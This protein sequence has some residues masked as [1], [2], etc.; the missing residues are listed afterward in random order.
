METQDKLN[1]KVMLLKNSKWDTKVFNTNKSH[2]TTHY[3]STEMLFG[4][5]ISL[6]NA[7]IEVMV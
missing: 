2:Q 4:P 3:S 7:E 5:L 6:S 1:E